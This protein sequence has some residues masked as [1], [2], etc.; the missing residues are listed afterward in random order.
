MF[1]MILR[2][3]L[4]PV[5]LEMAVLAISVRASLVKVSST[6]SS[7]RSRLYWEI[8]EFLGFTFEGMTEADGYFWPV[9][10]GWGYNLFNTENKTVVQQEEYAEER[11]MALR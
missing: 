8:M 6:P 1:S 9:F 4:A 11:R 5:C 7:A 3:P 2:K 10:I